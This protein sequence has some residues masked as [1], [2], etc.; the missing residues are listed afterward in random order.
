MMAYTSEAMSEPSATVA[1]ERVSVDFRKY[2][3]NPNLF[4]LFRLGARPPIGTQGRLSIGVAAVGEDGKLL[5]AGDGSIDLPKEGELAVGIDLSPSHS[6]GGFLLRR[7]TSLPCASGPLVIDAVEQIASLL[8]PQSKTRLRFHGFGFLPQARIRFG[9][10][11]VLTEW[12]SFSKLDAVLDLPFA[13]AGVLSAEFVIE[14][15]DGTQCVVTAN[16]RTIT[17]YSALSDPQPKPS[18]A[19][20]YHILGLPLRAGYDVK[21]LTSGDVDG[22]GLPDIFLTGSRMQGT[23]GFLAVLRNR[24]RLDQGNFFDDPEYYDFGGGSG[25]SV[26]VGDWNKD[27]KLDAAVT[28]KTQSKIVVFYQQKVRRLDNASVRRSHREVSV[29]TLSPKEILTRMALSI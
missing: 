12:Q 9:S 6:S 29:L 1:Q 26:V 13:P 3:D 16:P 17:F 11:A 23:G 21:E 22:D 5:A 14:H 10:T 7:S 27:G 19:A 18:D 2:R 25:E 8:D 24:G 15:P 28:S 4:D 20:S